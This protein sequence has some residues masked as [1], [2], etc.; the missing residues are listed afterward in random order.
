MDLPGSDLVGLTQEFQTYRRS[1][2]LAGPLVAVSAGREARVFEVCRQCCVRLEVVFDSEL[3]DEVHVGGAD[4]TACSG[5]NRADEVSGGEPTDE[6]DA[7][8][9]WA[10]VADESY[11]CPLASKRHRLAVIVV[12]AAHC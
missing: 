3:D 8:A 4:M 6:H 7:S 10:D 9:P 2:D 12:V 5:R 1:F 11:E